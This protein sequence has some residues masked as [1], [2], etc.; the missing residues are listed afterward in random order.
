[1]AGEPRVARATRTRVAGAE[2]VAAQDDDVP[3]QPADK[4][5]FVAITGVAPE[6]VCGQAERPRSPLWIGDVAR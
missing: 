6:I 3:D 4:Q 2:P 5:V 1:M